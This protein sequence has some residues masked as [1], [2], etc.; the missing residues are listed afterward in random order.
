MPSFTKCQVDILMRDMSQNITNS[1]KGVII[2]FEYFEF[3][4]ITLLSSKLSFNE[5]LKCEVVQLN[6]FL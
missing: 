6:S 5:L 2:P 3:V 4:R 1:T